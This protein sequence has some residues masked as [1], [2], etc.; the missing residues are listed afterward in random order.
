MDRRMEAFGLAQR[1]GVLCRALT[2]TYVVSHVQ[3]SA[4][5]IAE[6]ADAPAYW[7]LLFLDYDDSPEW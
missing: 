4:E 5:A 3:A 7:L 6:I 1:L 2:W